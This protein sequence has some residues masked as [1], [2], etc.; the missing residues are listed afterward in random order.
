MLGDICFITLIAWDVEGLV[1]GGIFTQF[2]GKIAV[3]YINGFVGFGQHSVKE[4]KAFSTNICP[5]PN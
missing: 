5:W 1:L 2:Y 4:C 3:I